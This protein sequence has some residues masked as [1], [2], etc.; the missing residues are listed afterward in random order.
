[1]GHMTKDC[2]QSCQTSNRGAT[3]SIGSVPITR[4]ATTPSATRNEQRQGRVFALIPGDT[5]NTEVVVSGTISICGKLAHTLIDSRSTHSFISMAFAETLNR[6]METLNYILCV[7]SPTRGSMLCSTIFVACEVF[8]RNATFYADLIPLDMRHFDVILGMDWLAKY[9]ATIDCALK[10]VIFRPPGQE[11]FYFEGKWVVSPPYLTS[12]MK[13]RKLINRGF[14]G[15]LCSVIT[16]PMVDI[17]LDN[18]PVVRDFLDVFPDELLGQFVDREIEFTIDVI[19]GTQPI[20]KTSYR[21]STTEMKELKTQL[22]ELLDKGF[23]HPSTSP[24]EAL[25]LFAKKKDDTL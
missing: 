15:Y 22:Q 14:Q 19:P 2:T 23:I 4:P 24:W 11:E 25:V 21:M 1:M 16:E 18:I 10:R 7:A 13:A 8:L 3:S 20:S 9:D 17:T 12:A 5:Q 6:P